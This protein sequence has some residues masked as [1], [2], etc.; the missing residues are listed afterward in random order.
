MSSH[1]GP[2]CRSETLRPVVNLQRQEACLAKPW[3]RT[4][5]RCLNGVWVLAPG[6]LSMRRPP[7]LAY[8]AIAANYAYRAI[9]RF[10]IGCLYRAACFAR[11]CVKPVS[12]AMSRRERPVVAELAVSGYHLPRSSWAE[13]PRANMT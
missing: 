10:L 4:A 2:S 5:Q 3:S 8:R 11:G 9:C 12:G 1:N 7:A 13:G 6:G